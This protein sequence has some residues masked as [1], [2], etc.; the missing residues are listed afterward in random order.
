MYFHLIWIKEKDWKKY[1]LDILLQW[2]DENFIRSF[3]SHWWVVVVS[4]TEYKEE[5]EAFWNVLIHLIYNEAE[6]LLLSKGDDLWES[7]YFFMFLWLN[8]EKINFIKNPI[9]EDDVKKIIDSTLIK[10]NEENKKFQ[11]Q[12]KLEEVK[13]RKKYEES[14]IKDWLR[15]INL[16]IDHIEQVLKAWKWIISWNDAKKLDEYLNEMKKIRLWTNFNKMASLILDV[17]GLLKKVEEEI[18][19][20]NDSYKFLI[21]KN[22]SV[23]NIDVLREYFYSNRI[24]E[25]AKLQPAWLTTSESIENMFWR[26]A[27]Y[28]KLLNR[29]IWYNRDKTSFEWFFGI[30][31]NLIEYIIILVLVILSLLRLFGSVSWIG[32]FSIYLLPALWWLWF[33]VYL[34]NNLEL[35]WVIPRIVWFAVLIL[36]YWQGLTLLLNTF[37]L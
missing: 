16:N 29:D 34:L 9:S 30:V 14:S 20:E 26:S 15:I 23:T 12:Q 21:D 1:D 33:L 37:S 17:H 4:L 18:F 24:S 8:L 22:S 36:I 27:L 32:N 19:K 25:K 11:E 3:L 13:E 5:P 35:K 10:I 6:I 28:L 2:W 31:I 7:I